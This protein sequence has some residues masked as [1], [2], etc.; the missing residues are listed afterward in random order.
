MADLEEIADPH[1]SRLEAIWNEEWE[2]NL[3]DAALQKVKR[4]VN[5][6]H[7]QMFYLHVLKELPVGEV[8]RRVGSNIG[9]VYLAKHR[10]G[11]LLKKEIQTLGGSSQ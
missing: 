4:Q 8:A 5:P 9:Q 1:G 2:A 6:K 11:R 7:Y 10:V 3:L